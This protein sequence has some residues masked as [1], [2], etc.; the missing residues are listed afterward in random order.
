MP[1]LGNWKGFLV[2][3]G[4][5]WHS[6]V[7][8][9][10]SCI[11]ERARSHKAT[12]SCTCRLFEI[13]LIRHKLYKHD[14][15][16]TSLNVLFVWLCGASSDH[17]TVSSLL[18]SESSPAVFDVSFWTHWLSVMAASF[19]SSFH[20]CSLYFRRMC[21]YE[22]KA[23]LEWWHCNKI[24]FHTSF[25]KGFCKF[26][27]NFFFATLVQNSNRHAVPVSLRNPCHVL[28]TLPTGRGAV[29]ECCIQWVINKR[30]SPLEGLFPTSQ[31]GEEDEL[32]HLH[33]WSLTNTV[34][35]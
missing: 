9:H 7:K 3:W 31:W 12:H 8:P 29:W 33:L 27:F 16:E 17:R 25:L 21:L 6:F 26:S 35:F 24:R 15:K 10:K 19:C 20:T 13:F 30:Q 2:S 18:H 32:Q 23:L 5:D 11:I 22:L 1:F 14:L 4:K 34:L 28:I